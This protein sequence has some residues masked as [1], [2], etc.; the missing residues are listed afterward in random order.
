VLIITRHL[1]QLIT[2]IVVSGVQPE[3]SD[4]HEDIDDHV[5][6]LSHIMMLAVD[7]GCSAE[8]AA[9]CEVVRSES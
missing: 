1:L 9:A 8:I 3:P 5:T 7:C 4:G 6:S 2:Y